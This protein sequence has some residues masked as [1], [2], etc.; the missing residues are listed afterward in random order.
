[1]QVGATVTWLQTTA[2]GSCWDFCTPRTV[3]LKDG[4]GLWCLSHRAFPLGQTSLHFRLCLPWGE[5]EA[6]LQDL[7]RL[8]AQGGQL[9]L[10]GTPTVLGSLA[11]CGTALHS[12]GGIAGSRGAVLPAPGLSAFRRNSRFPTLALRHFLSGSIYPTSPVSCHP[13][14]HSPSVY[15]SKA[16]FSFLPAALCTRCS[17][18]TCCSLCLKCFSFCF[19]TDTCLFI[20]PHSVQMFLPQG[21]SESVPVWV[22][23]FMCP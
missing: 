7:S 14:C 5:G 6:L 21:S 9:C 2:T 20:W 22:P 1:M 8:Q 16:P 3:H 18:C 15:S 10:G 4:R 12:C 11:L 13:Q 19:L 23:C 17:L